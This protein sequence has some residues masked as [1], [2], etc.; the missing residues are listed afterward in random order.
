MRDFKDKIAVITGA[1]SGMGRAY[2]LEFAKLGSKLALNDFDKNG[3]EETAN[4]IKNN[5]QNEIYTECFDV[6]D[7]VAM[8][9]FAQNVAQQLGKAHVV[10]NNAGIEGSVEAFYH[11]DV[12]DIKKVMNVNFYGVVNGCKAFLPQL[13]E[14]NEG[15]IV[16]VSSI[17]GLVGTPNHSDYCASKFAVR[18]FTEA[19]CAEF[20]NS[21]ISITCLH[22]G[23]IDT[24]IVR[25]D[26][27]K[28]FS[29]KYLSTPPEKIVK[30]VIKSIKRK[31]VKIVYGKSSFKT[32]LG[33]NI[34]PQGILVKIIWNE[35]KKV[36][37]T[38]KYSDFIK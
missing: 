17:F 10:I 11:T 30:H 2:A 33:S 5:Y 37:N 4:L 31:K 35:M 6:S 1:G 8:L 3:L 25:K 34:V 22:P 13:V 21:P 32:W 7:T 12:A 15:A 23:G 38:K 28:A 9:N 16:N 27:G 19:L 36:V 24:N 20:V 29:K 18:G 26:G 14:N